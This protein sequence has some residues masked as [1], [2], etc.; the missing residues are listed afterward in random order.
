MILAAVCLLYGL[1]VLSAG[2][3]TGFFLV[4]FLLGA[5]FAISCLAV[6]RHLITGI[7]APAKIILSILAAVLILFFILIQARIISGFRQLPEENADYLIV[8]GAQIRE[9]GPSAVLQFRLDAAAD[10]LNENEGTMCIVS[11]GQGYNEPFPEAEG[12]RESLVRAGISEDRILM[13]TRSRNTDENIEFSKAFIDPAN[14]SVCI[15]TN[16]FHVYR[17]L[18]LA[19]KHGLSHVSGLPAPS[20]LLFLPNNMLRETLGVIKDIYLKGRLLSE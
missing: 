2:S 9:S 4:W 14:D 17:A 8:L 19:K 10:Y 12:M 13:E 20:S 5:F 16:N 7:P 11:G 15:V 3:G 18:F 6:K 1:L